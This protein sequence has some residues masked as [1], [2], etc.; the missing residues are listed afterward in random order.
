M[1][2]GIF[3]AENMTSTVDG[4]KL[5]SAKKAANI[6]NGMIVKLGALESGEKNL[7][8]AADVAANTDIVYLVDGVAVVYSEE[9]TKGLDDY[10]NVAGTAFRVRKAEVGDIFSVSES[11][12]TAL[13]SAPV[14]GNFVETPATGTKLLEKATSLTAGV[15]FGAKIIDKYTFGTRAIPMVRLEVTKVL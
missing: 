9:T 15:S 6:E 14:L 11:V 12:I 7:Y 1:A 3:V 13:A 10:I 2:Y 8:V 4:S 5:R